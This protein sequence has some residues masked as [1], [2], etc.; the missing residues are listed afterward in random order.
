MNLSILTEG[1]ADRQTE[2]DRERERISDVYVHISDVY[3]WMC[4]LESE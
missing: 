2:T 3:W 1:E 4:V